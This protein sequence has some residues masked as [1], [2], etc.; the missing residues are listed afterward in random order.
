VFVKDSQINRPLRTNFRK[1]NVYDVLVVED[2]GNCLNGR[3]ILLLAT[4]I[5]YLILYSYTLYI[6]INYYIQQSECIKCNTATCCGIGKFIPVIS[7]KTYCCQ[8]QVV[9]N[10]TPFRV[11]ATPYMA[12]RPHSLDTPQSVGLPWT[13]DRPVAET[14]T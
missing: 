1:K 8:W 10:T 11:M 12:W 3:A 9:N 4:D 13:S 5:K 2:Y 6:F 14:C 7:N